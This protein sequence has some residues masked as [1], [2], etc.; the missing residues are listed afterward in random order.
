M[1]K[2]IIVTLIIG[3]L[4]ISYWL[5]GRIYQKSRNSKQSS[6]GSRQS[7]IN[8]NQSEVGGKQ[9]TVSSW[10]LADKNQE[11]KTAFHESKSVFVPYWSVAT[12]E[13]QLEDY[14][15]VYYFGVTTANL[16]INRRDTGYLQ[17]KNFTTVINS[18]QESI[19]VLR[20]LDEND[21]HTVLDSEN[22]QNK[23]I[24]DFITLTQ[25]NR[26]KGI[27]LDLEISTLFPEAIEE[28]ISRFAIKLFNSAKKVKL[29][30]SLLVYGDLFYRKRPYNLTVLAP[31]VDEVV[32]MAYD[33]H[34]SQG[35]PG[36]NFPFLGKEKYGYDFQTMILDYAKLV[37]KEKLTIVFGMFGYEWSVDEKKK[38]IKPAESL[39]LNEIK[40][41]FL[42][43]CEWKDCVIK[44]D[45]LSG[46]TEINYI[47][48]QLKDDFA[49]L[50]YN[51]V[52]F[53]DEQSVA[54]KSD[55]LKKQGI[56]SAAYWAWGYY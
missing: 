35:E 31:Q 37:P 12:D 9:S 33:Y 4:G 7:A 41:K 46:E 51:I 18:T 53:E 23:I 19:L 43:K 1:K 3:I 44:R 25:E 50:Y 39:S 56:G 10:Q 36:P 14:D 16:G 32:V 30:T 2:I 8:K 5:G 54:L 48:S 55:W 13:A 15:K 26:F 28:K 6:V 47:T 34:K 11:N 27:A 49:Y 45:Q 20:M 17:L 52:W 38:P 40:K 29:K 42:E 22:L 21:I 24:E